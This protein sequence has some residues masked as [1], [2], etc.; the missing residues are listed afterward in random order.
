MKRWITPGPDTIQ[1]CWLKKLAASPGSTNKEAANCK[2]SSEMANTGQNNPDKEG[3]PQTKTPSKYWLIT[4]IWVGIGKTLEKKNI[5]MPKYQLLVDRAVHQKSKTSETNP[6][7]TW[8]DY[9]KA[10]DS[11][12]HKW[13][14]PC[15]A[16]YSNA[17]TQSQPNKA[18]WSVK[19]MKVMHCPHCCST[20]ASNP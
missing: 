3:S 1:G 17:L 14:L 12:S 19:Y 4:C 15:L 6:R 5:T 20:Q 8:I 11:M 18:P 9:K 7:T 16:L 10:Y 2:H 13:L